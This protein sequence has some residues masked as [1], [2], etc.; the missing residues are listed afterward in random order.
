MVRRIIQPIPDNHPWQDRVV[1]LMCAIREL[2]GSARSDVDKI[3]QSWGHKFWRDLPI[4]GAEMRET[5][6]QG[7]WE[8]RVDPDPYF[9]GTYTL[10]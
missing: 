3:E 8:K 7:P 1:D 6:N 4:F 2:K 10:D 5:R 9:P